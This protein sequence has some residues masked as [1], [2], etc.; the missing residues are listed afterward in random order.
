MAGF[1]S[2][3]MR[4]AFGSAGAQG[5]A[6][7]A[8]PLMTRLYS[9]ADYGLYGQAATYAFFLGGGLFLTYETA[10]SLPL[11]DLRRRA[12]WSACLHWAPCAA[13]LLMAALAFS[14]LTGFDVEARLL[15]A[16]SSAATGVIIGSQCLHFARGHFGRAS[17]L[18]AIDA[19]ATLVL[20][21]CLVYVHDGMLLGRVGGDLIAAG[22]AVHGLRRDFMRLPFATVRRLA[23]RYVFL[24]TLALPQFALGALAQT[25][26]IGLMAG[27]YSTEVVGRYWLAYNITT[28]PHT[29]LGD[30]AM[31]VFQT[32]AANL[33]KAR[34]S[35]AKAW[36]VA[37]L[38][39]VVLPLPLVAI[40]WLAGPPIFA[41]VLGEKYRLAG[42]YSRFIVVGWYLGFLGL[43]SL[44]MMKLER[45]QRTLVAFEVFCAV[46]RIGAVPVAFLVFNDPAEGA[47]WWASIAGGMHGLLALPLYV[48]RRAF[49]AHPPAAP[50]GLPVAK[51]D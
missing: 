46:L 20:Q 36:R 41:L 19:L 24:P 4:A 47:V 33:M 50:A 2:K 23:Q 37:T 26:P 1:H 39:C 49:E 48:F 22:I 32:Q 29:I 40:L 5:L 12:L 13:L 3:L 16:T 25:L 7:L 31:S 38:A 28:I 44:V 15:L 18:K 30:P 8:L 17:S 9:P 10:I 42:E 21:V 51:A 45:R 43:P 14:P 11:P 34:Q 35:P 6:M 27:Y